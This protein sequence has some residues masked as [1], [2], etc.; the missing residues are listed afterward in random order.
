MNIESHYR[1]LEVIYQM[2]LYL[3]GREFAMQNVSSGIMTRKICISRA[4]GFQYWF[5]NM[6]LG[7][8]QYNLYYSIAGFDSVPPR[9]RDLQAPLLD[10]DFWKKD[11]MH[12]RSF[13]FFVD[14]DGDDAPFRAVIDSADSIMMLLDRLDVP[15]ELV[16]SG[17]GIHIKV[18]YDDSLRGYSFYPDASNSIY[19]FYGRLLGRLHREYSELVDSMNIAD[20]SRLCKIP[21][22]LAIYPGCVRQ[23]FQFNSSLEWRKFKSGYGAMSAPE[24]WIGKIYKRGRFTFNETGRAIN[25]QGVLG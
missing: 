1:R 5:R 3:K 18:P 7:K 25:L 8:K 6:H 22:S 15:Y 23:S 16:F 9:S 10:G 12:M 20:K 17:R 19:R 4:Q 21:Y 11:W 2:F 14:I 24:Y 13:D